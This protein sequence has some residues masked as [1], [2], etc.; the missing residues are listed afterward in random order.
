MQQ[1]ST[2]FF[3]MMMQ[4]LQPIAHF[5][6]SMAVVRHQIRIAERVHWLEGIKAAELCIDKQQGA[7]RA[8]YVK[9]REYARKIQAKEERL[10]LLR[11][12]NSAP[13]RFSR[14]V[15]LIRMNAQPLL[16]AERERMIEKLQDEIDTFEYQNERLKP[17]IRD[18]LME[19]EVAVVERQRIIQANPQATEMTYAELQEFATPEALKSLQAK[20]ITARLTGLPETAAAALLDVPE[21][22]LSEMFELINQARSRIA[23][24]AAAKSKTQLEPPPQNNGKSDK[25]FF[26]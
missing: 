18:A 7:L 2:N 22:Q 16:T 9:Q 13:G 8:N 20:Y 17:L 21:D 26:N 19:L 25:Q 3:R 24:A 14:W 12:D 23:S 11:Q 5:S 6:N 1:L 4:P 15:N 10:T